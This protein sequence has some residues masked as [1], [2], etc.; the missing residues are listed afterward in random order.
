MSSP[1]V[2]ACFARVK[3]STAGSV[4]P[5]G[6][7]S[8]LERL[9]WVQ[10]GGLKGFENT[11]DLFFEDRNI[12]LNSNPNFFDI[13]T[14]IIMYQL[15]A[16]PGDIIPRD[17]FTVLTNFIRK[18]LRCLPNNFNL[19]NYSILNQGIPFKRSNRYPF[20]ITFD[21]QNRIAYVFKANRI[22]T[23]H[24]LDETPLKCDFSSMG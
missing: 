9:V 19:T 22:V 10:A 14:E 24:R 15:V 3:S 23:L 18:P 7:P 11:V 5:K 2:T 8:G 16:H 1:I 4:S 13:D 6:I 12:A 20:C 21:L 17:F